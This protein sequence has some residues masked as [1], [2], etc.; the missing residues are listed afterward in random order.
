[1]L[2]L[3]L[4]I[5]RTATARRL[6]WLGTDLCDYNAPLLAK[7]FSLHVSLARFRQ[8]WNEART[9]L[10]N[11][12]RLGFD[13]VDLAQ[14]PETVGSQRNPM[15]HLGATPHRNCA[16]LVS[17]ADSWDK[18][19]AKRSSATRRHDRAKQKKLAGRGA[20]RFVS[21]AEP[22]DDAR[23]VE[24]LMA[25]KAR[26]FA[27]MG[28]DNIFARP[29]VRDFFIDVASAADTRAITHVSR[30]DV[31]E[32]TAAVNFGLVFGDC[33]YHVLASYDRSSELARFGPGAAHLHELMRFAIGRGF[34]KFDLSVGNERFKEEWSDSK[35]KLYDHIAVASLRGIGAALP[36]MVTR[37]IKRWIKWH[38][39][40]WSAFRKAR[41]MLGS[42]RIAR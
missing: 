14:M 42:L 26:W 33:Y 40:V 2:L 22:A 13:L 8:L 34:R 18:L 38:P 17:L 10:R 32:A 31:G 7:D 1:M 36:I 6:T 37:Q 41:A 25:Q 5:E 29:G 23:T 20:V 12:R 19:Y 27:E 15:L 30:L 39:A 35:L 24:T 21:A 9:M 16:Y 4:G 3:P 11:H 28:V